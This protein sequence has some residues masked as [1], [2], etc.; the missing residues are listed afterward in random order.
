MYE[1]RRK[2]GDK[3]RLVSLGASGSSLSVISA[4]GAVAWLVVVSMLSYSWTQ[5]HVDVNKQWSC[6]LNLLMASIYQQFMALTH[7]AN[8]VER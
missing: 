4:N 8:G 2:G 6:G 5:L 1:A 7:L 3:I